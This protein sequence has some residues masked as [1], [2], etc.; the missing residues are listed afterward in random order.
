[1][2]IRVEDIP[3]EG[4]RL[5]FKWGNDSFKGFTTIHD[6]Y[7]MKV[8]DYLHVDIFL[9][10]EKNHI[11]V[12]GQ[13]NGKFEVQCHRCLEDFHYPVNINVETFL[14]KQS[15]I[16]P[17]AEEEIE[18]DRED[19][20]QEFFDGVEIDVDLIV[21]EEIFLSLPQV[22]LCSENCK[23]LCPLCGTNRNINECN[24]SLMANSPFAALLNMK[25]SLFSSK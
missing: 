23:G 11:R 18:L 12:A 3:R 4:K 1:M 25:K 17:G 24:C 10:R 20:D 22:M 9:T 21:A 14:Y 7:D 2:K 19:L 15:D 8:I 6:P 16:S 5:V 13:I